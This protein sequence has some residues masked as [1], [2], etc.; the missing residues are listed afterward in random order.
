MEWKGHFPT[1]G[2]QDDHEKPIYKIPRRADFFLLS[3]MVHLNTRDAWR[4]G[5]VSKAAAMQT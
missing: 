5:S 4:D 3:F 2:A 1:Q